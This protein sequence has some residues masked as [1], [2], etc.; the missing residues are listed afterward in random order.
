MADSS[1][2]R[3]STQV[4]Q[5]INAPRRAVYHA[6]LDRGAVAT[7]Q[8][9]DNMRM[10]I[11]DFDAREGGAFRISLTYADPADSLGGKTSDNTDTY[12]GWFARLIPDTTIAQVVEFESAK[13]EFAGQM[14]ITVTLADRDGGTDVTYRCDDI[15]PGIRPDDNEIGCRMSLRKLA[16]LL[17]SSAVE[18][19]PSDSGARA[20]DL[21][22]GEQAR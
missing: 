4:T 18:R 11:H 20:E 3:A 14:R 15:P 7:W 10:L 6:F 21:D 9:P 22:E 2:M 12:H 5:F 1:S 19:Q 17:E 16:A 13:A 8:H